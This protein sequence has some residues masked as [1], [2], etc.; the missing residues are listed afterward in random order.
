M[1]GFARR[2]VSGCLVTPAGGI[3]HF[4]LGIMKS[5]IASRPASFLLPDM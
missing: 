2:A 4:R 3:F 1:S 5:R